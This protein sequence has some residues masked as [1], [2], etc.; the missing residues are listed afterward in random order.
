MNKVYLSIVL[1]MAGLFANAQFFW[2]T[3][4]TNWPEA[5]G[6]KEISIASPNVAW[7]SSYDGSGNGTYPKN[8]AVTTNGGSTWTARTVT[9]VPS[10]GLI[11]DIAAVDADIAYV[12]TAPASGSASSNGIW[13]TTNGGTT[14]T[15]YTGSTVFN[16]SASFANHVY[17]WNENEGYCGGDPV[18][19]K[20]EMYKTID[21]G[22]SW[23]AI[24]TAPA[25]INA[26]EFTYVGIKKV[27]GNTIWLGTSQGRILRSTDKGATWS[28]FSSPALD[29]GGVIFEGSSANFAFSDDGLKGLLITDDNGAVFMYSTTDGGA[30]WDDAFPEGTWYG[31]DVAAV[32]GTNG[33]FV[34][35][36]VNFNLP[37]GTSYSKDA[38][39][40]WIEIDSGEQ[41]GRLEFFDPVTGW[42]GGFSDGSGGSTG[43]FKFSGDLSDLGVKDLNKSN[44]QVYPNP[45]RDIVNF[46]SDRQITQVNIIDLSG[47]V[48][49]RAK[50]TNKVNVSSFAPGV[51]IAQ[52]RYSDGGI[53]NTKIVVK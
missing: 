38:G 7:I 39:I 35:S 14:W 32:P 27:V 6:V 52:V 1:L 47:K 50:D 17:F 46:A 28:A 40:T 44:L 30:T 10:A 12:V 3:Q 11:S 9:G 2:E 33:T 19:N 21:G 16:N 53:Q 20:F 23:T 31:D 18:N 49:L 43:I 45:A 22:A 37:M 5:W 13:K 29:F 36:G 8:V 51:Y 4:A 26:D 25:P 24:T 15:K 48:L 42:S 34:T 41:R